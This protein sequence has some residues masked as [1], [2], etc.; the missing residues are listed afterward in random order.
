ML[1]SIVLPT[2]PTDLGDLSVDDR[3]IIAE[4]A[5]LVALVPEFVRV[6][7]S[8][9][10]LSR[11]NARC[12]MELT[13]VEID[14]LARLIPAMALRIEA[15]FDPQG[16]NVWWATGQPAGQLEPRVLVELVPRYK[17]VPYQY[18]DST[19]LPRADPASRFQIF[20]ALS[21]VTI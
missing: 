7:G 13:H 17:D 9:I 16:L 8:V 2:N 11:G 4:D 12:V 19:A 6:P 10:I 3:Y 15:A 1:E 5:G 20:E 18:A 21:V 14:A